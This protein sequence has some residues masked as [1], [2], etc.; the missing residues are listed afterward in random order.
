MKTNLNS[1]NTGCKSS[2]SLTYSCTTV[3]PVW[4]LPS[5]L[6]FWSGCICVFIPALLKLEE[7]DDGGRERKS[8]TFLV[9]QWLRLL[10]QGRGLGSIPSQR[11]GTHIPQL[12]V[13]MPQLKIL[14]AEAK[15]CFSQKN[16]HLKEREKKQL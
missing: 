14:H 16:K 3:D 2:T 13:H 6:P 12:R 5:A 7:K 1:M 10:S 15:T 4:A 9:V 8:G 11:T